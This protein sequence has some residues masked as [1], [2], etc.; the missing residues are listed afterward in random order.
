V[1]NYWHVLAIAVD[2]VTLRVGHVVLTDVNCVFFVMTGV[3]NK[4]YY[5]SLTVQ[6]V[7]NL[8]FNCLHPLKFT[9]VR[10]R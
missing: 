1:R 5:Y 6:Y 7:I 2:Y 9:C 8:Y 3:A 10:Y 4:K